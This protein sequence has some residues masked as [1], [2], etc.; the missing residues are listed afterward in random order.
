MTTIR[1]NVDFPPWMLE[2]LDLEAQRLQIPRQAVIKFLIDQ[3]LENRNPGPTTGT[4]VQRVARN[5][6]AE[7]LSI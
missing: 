4:G 5:N 7:R 2:A 1:V 6:V 3:A